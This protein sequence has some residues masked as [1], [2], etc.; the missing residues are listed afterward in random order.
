[1]F[2]AY[3]QGSTLLLLPLVGLILCFFAFTA[4]VIRVYLGYRRGESVDRVASLPLEDGPTPEQ[5]ATGGR[6]S[7][8]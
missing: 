7:A 5:T 2:Q 8:R 3:F 6:A 1:M 4:V